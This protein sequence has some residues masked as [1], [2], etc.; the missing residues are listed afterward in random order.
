MARKPTQRALWEGETIGADPIVLN[1][2]APTIKHDF[3]KIK[4]TRRALYTMAFVA[5]PLTF[6]IWI[7]GAINPSIPATPKATASSVSTNSSQGKAPAIAAV[8]IW[9]AHDPAPLPGG[10]LV[11]WDGYETLPAPKAATTAT[12]DKP[13]TYRTEIH[14][15]T[16]ATGAADN[17]LYFRSSVEVIVDP[18]LGAKVVG[19]P[20]LLPV[21]PSSTSDWPSQVVWDGFIST[22]PPKAVSDA[23]E[24]WATAFTS[25]KPEALRLAVGDPDPNHSYMPLTGATASGVSV[26][27]AAGI[28]LADPKAAP[29]RMLVRVTFQVAW[30]TPTDPNAAAPVL[31]IITYDL[32]VDAADTAS[33]RVV[34][35]GGPGSAPVLKPYSTAIKNTQIKGVAPSDPATPSTPAP[36]APSTPAPSGGNST[37]VPTP[38]AFDGTA[39]D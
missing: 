36:A 27:A 6:L 15:F 17:T 7:N 34:S 14:Y 11:A 4:W 1:A 24:A 8:Q 26:T 30:T 37:T 39:H 2:S 9:L 20:T 10:R 13:V 5:T 23:V 22:Q 31:P 19:D 16:L 38:G 21:I 29:K 35:W 12:G 18:I 28:P 33:P 3:W 25:G 32:L